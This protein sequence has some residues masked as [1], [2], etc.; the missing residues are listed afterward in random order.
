MIRAA[1]FP[2]PHHLLTSLATFWCSDDADLI[3]VEEVRNWLNE[4][5]MPFQIGYVDDP[6]LEDEC[7]HYI[8]FQSHYDAIE[9]K[10]RWF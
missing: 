10:M 5:D 1:C 6:D 8:F 9:F 4:H 7:D 3:L 2:I